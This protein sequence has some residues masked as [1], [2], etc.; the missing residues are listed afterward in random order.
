M[1]N[2]IL[3]VLAGALLLTL[4]ACGGG[5]PEG[6]VEIA[7]TDPEATGNQQTVVVVPPEG[8]ELSA[9]G[10]GITDGNVVVTVLSLSELPLPPEAFL[11]EVPGETHTVNGREIIIQ[12]MLNRLMA[13]TTIDGTLT[14]FT[15]QGRTEVPFGE[16]EE[17]ILLDIASTA[18]F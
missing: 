1:N 16:V 4:A 8:W 5:V 3:L 17:Q 2:R 14:T 10:E 18:G 12:P 13:W 9:S 7:N 6:A 11:A 15:M